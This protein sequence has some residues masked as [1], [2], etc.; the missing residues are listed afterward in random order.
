MLKEFAI[1]FKTGIPSEVLYSSLL[2]SVIVIIIGLMMKTVNDKWRYIGRV[3][4]VEYVVVVICS[5]VLFRPKLSMARIEITPFWTYFA[6]YNHTYGVSIWD[7]ILNIV[8]F[9]PLGIF[10]AILF[11]KLKIGKAVLIGVLSSVCIELS[12]L[13]L[14][15]GIV[16]FDDVLHNT[17][18]CCLGF[19]VT[20]WLTSIMSKQLKHN[21][22]NML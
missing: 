14:Q 4:F 15:R 8:L 6:V 19:L 3:L 18:G 2:I 13:V 5:T 7:I 12:Q 21:N 10:L 17:I 22:L 16:Q 11:P 1:F 20:K 9:F